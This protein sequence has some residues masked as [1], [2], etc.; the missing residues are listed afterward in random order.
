MKYYE[1]VKP[2]VDENVRALCVKPYPLHKNGCPNFN[3]KDGCPPS[4]ELIQNV[5]DLEQDVYIIYN[6]YNFKD[7]VNKMKVKHPDWSKR[8]LRC[9][10]YWQGSARKNLKQKI[11]FV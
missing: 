3:K 1:K 11:S 7:H 10:L 9:C 6:K 2:V 5:I 8:Q 4:A